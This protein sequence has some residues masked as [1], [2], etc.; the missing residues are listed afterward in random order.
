MNRNSLLALALSFVAVS[1]LAAPVKYEFAGIPWHLAPV[2]VSQRLEAAGFSKLAKIND[3]DFNAYVFQGILDDEPFEALVYFTPDERLLKIALLFEITP[4][5]A[6]ARYAEMKEVLTKKYGPPGVDN[7]YYDPPYDK[8]TGFEEL[9]LKMDKAHFISVF[10]GEPVADVATVAIS[11]KGTQLV[12]SYEAPD[13]GAEVER[14]QK[15]KGAA[16]R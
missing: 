5:T 7:G 11:G 16:G 8:I 9:A 6:L 14:V 10:K 1:A 2:N 13:W 4:Q 3:P 15:R 12:V